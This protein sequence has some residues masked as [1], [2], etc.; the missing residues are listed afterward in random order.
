MDMR[1]NLKEEYLRQSVLTASPAELTVALFNGCIKDLKLAEVAMEKPAD[2][3]CVNTHMIKAQ[4]IISELMNS[5]NMEYEISKQLL[6]IYKYLLKTIRQMNVTKDFSGLPGIL[7][8]LTSQRDTWEKI[9]KAGI[10]E[11]NDGSNQACI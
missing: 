11:E 4:K 6:P 3:V 8:I 9:S 1:R 7:E 5:L 2:F 10:S